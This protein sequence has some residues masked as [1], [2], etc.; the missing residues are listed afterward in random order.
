MRQEPN[1]ITA[2]NAGGLRQFPIRTP[3]AARVGEFRRSA[4]G[5]MRLYEKTAG[6]CLLG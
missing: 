4:A 6:G 2:P 3:L 1:K 5:P